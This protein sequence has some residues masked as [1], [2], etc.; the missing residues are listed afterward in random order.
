MKKPNILFLMTDQMQAKA[1]NNSECITP[2]LDKLKQKSLNF[3]KAYTPNAVCSPA[4][5]SLMTGL[6]PHNHGVLSVTHTVDKDQ[7]V[8]RK[9]PHWAERLKE[10]GYNTGYFGKWHV[11]HSENPSLFGWAV[12]GSMKSELYKERK[13]TLKT[14]ALW[15]IDDFSRSLEIKNDGYNTSLFAG[16]CEGTPSE[17]DLGL[18]VCLAHEFLDTATK[19]DAPW[20]CFVSVL[21][22]HDPFVC[23][24]IAFNKYDENQISLDDNLFDEGRDKP[25]IYR[26]AARIWKDFSEEDHRFTRTC[27]YASI[28]EIDEQYGTLIDRLV[29]EG[30]WDNTLVIFTTD[31][32]E[33]LGSH[34][35]YCKNFSACEEIYNIPLLIGG[36]KIRE[37]ESDVRIGLHDIAQTIL[38]FVGLNTIDTTDSRSFTSVLRGDAPPQNSDEGFAEYF[39]TRVFLTQRVIWK[40]DWKYV[41]NGFDEDEMYNLAEDPLEMRNLIENSLYKDKQKELLQIMW[42]K[43][44]ETGDKTL[45]NTQYPILQIASHGPNIAG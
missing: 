5:A 32:G 33:M 16:V 17:R 25:G 37:G 8:L 41:F 44:K 1:F 26:K 27:Y 13:R 15:E 31:H 24:K 30:L 22:P 10:A 36:G 12:N 4:R 7:F 39:G 11:E 38:D 23:G 18:S 6:L 20:C 29:K 34:G 14:K 21:E 28:T 3:T 9:S 19:E 42:K 2:N 43:V 45:L 35:M 40:G